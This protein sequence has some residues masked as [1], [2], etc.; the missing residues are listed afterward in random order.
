MEAQPQNRI[1]IVSDFDKTL[2]P[3]C[4]G[5]LF[6]YLGLDEKT[7]FAE[8]KRRYTEDRTEIDARRQRKEA[9]LPSE[10]RLR[11]PVQRHLYSPEVAYIN[12]LLRDNRLERI[13]PITLEV[14]RGLGS[15]VEFYPGVPEFIQQMKE[16]VRS[17]PKWARHDI[18]LEFYIVSSGIAE[19][20]FG[21]GIA[22]HC[23]GIFALELAAD[24][25]ESTKDRVTEITSPM[26]FTDKTQFI[27][28]IHK[29]H[30]V[31]VNDLVPLEMRRIAGDCIIYVG[32]GPTDVPCMS[33]VNNMGGQCF[34]VYRNDDRPIQEDGNFHDAFTL[35]EHGRVF[36]YGP[37]DYT[38]GT[39]TRKS[40]EMA[41]LKAA[42]RIVK[43]KEEAIRTRTKPSVKF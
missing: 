26:T 27:H 28:R 15:E 2:S 43:R 7:Y 4:T 16:W 40:L 35:R 23:D 17:N 9:S 22:K 41:V 11:Y 10:L 31:G 25:I 39:Q 38:K 34:A 6:R 36:G 19:I 30:D 20:I 12:P 29:G 8:V 13:K 37:A 33:T 1:A 21:S 5:P 18:A 42:D 14:L 24:D 32:D 3:G